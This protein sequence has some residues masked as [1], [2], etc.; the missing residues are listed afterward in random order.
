[1]S[2]SWRSRRISSSGGAVPAARAAIR[3]RRGAARGDHRHDS[4]AVASAAGCPATDLPRRH[5]RRSA[6]TQA[7]CRCR[8]HDASPADA[9]DADATAPGPRG[10]SERQVVPVPKAASKPP[11][12]KATPTPATTKAAPPA[13]KAPTAASKSGGAGADVANVHIE[14]VEFPFPGYLE[15]I[16]RQV[17]LNFSPDNPRQICGPRWRS[18]SS[19]TALSS[20][21]VSSSDRRLWL[22]SRSPG[23]RRK[24]CRDRSGRCR[25]AFPMTCCQSFSASI[26]G[27][28][29]DSLNSRGASLAV[30]IGCAIASLSRPARC[31]GHHPRRAYWAAVYARHQAR[32]GRP[33]DP[34]CGR[35]LGTRNPSARSGLRRRRA[36]DLARGLRHPRR[37]REL[38]AVRQARR[39]GGRAGVS[40]S[41][42]PARHRARRGG[43][44]GR[45]SSRFCR[46]FRSQ[47]AGLADGRPRRVRRTQALVHGRAGR[48][49]D[50]GIRLFVTGRSTSSTAMA[51]TRVP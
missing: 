26:R 4:G 8:P 21:S 19:V 28:S 27:Y 48:G 51:R 33:A 6:R 46:A 35:R 31:A 24:S 34:R 42:L 16:V 1:M 39:R 9:A 17:A 41:Q 20:T 7:G 49:A 38:P 43:P 15:N 45:T 18:S 11:P 44:Q 37:E 3:R 40:G 12:P 23:C 30:L 47:F 50:A 10:A 29:T 25:R 2:G 36:A 13:A 22:R 14:G 32:R 5:C